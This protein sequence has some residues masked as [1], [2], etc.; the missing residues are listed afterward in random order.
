M[1]TSLRETHIKYNNIVS[2]NQATFSTYVPIVYLFILI[3]DQRNLG[4]PGF[5]TKS[6][7]LNLLGWGL[8][9]AVRVLICSGVSPR[10]PLPRPRPNPATTAPL[11]WATKPVETW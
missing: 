7:R 4:A 2:E 5:I 8:P 6:T 11:S 10:V 3:N 1:T 9:E